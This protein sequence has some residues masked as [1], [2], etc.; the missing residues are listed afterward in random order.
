MRPTRPPFC[1]PAQPLRPPAAFSKRPELSAG[2]GHV[3]LVEY[4]EEEPALLGRMGMGMRL[5]RRC[6]CCCCCSLCTCVLLLPLL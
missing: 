1:P 4:L 3:L 2:S 6:C 5:V